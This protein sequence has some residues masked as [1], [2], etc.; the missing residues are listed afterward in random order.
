MIGW[1]NKNEIKK[2]IILDGKAVRKEV[3][4]ES[5]EATSDGVSS[6]VEMSRVAE[7]QVNL[8][9]FFCLFS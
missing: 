6:E 5:T 8:S 3:E 4:V 9:V 7:V 1:L 2:I